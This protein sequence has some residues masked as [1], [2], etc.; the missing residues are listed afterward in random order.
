MTEKLKKLASE[1]KAEG[2]SLAPLIN[3]QN[4]ANG[5]APSY[6]FLSLLNSRGICLNN[7][8]ILSPSSQKMFQVLPPS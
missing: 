5:A 4:F 2:K 7:S 6:F 8:M 3:T 1:E